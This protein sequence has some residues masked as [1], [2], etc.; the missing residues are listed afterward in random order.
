MN[1]KVMAHDFLHKTSGLISRLAIFIIYFWFGTLKIAGISPANSLV[2]SLLQK[3]LPLLP[4]NQFSPILG[5]YE[6][7]IGILFLIPRCERLAIALLIPHLITTFLPLIF[8]PSISWQSFL[9][10]TL[11]GQYMIKNLIIAALVFSIYSKQRL[12]PAE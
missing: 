7:I 9:A 8:L 12:K 3:T 10:P 4:F 2:T 1:Q 5:W 11:E 6:V